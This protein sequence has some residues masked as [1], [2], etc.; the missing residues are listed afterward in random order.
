[1]STALSRSMAN[2]QKTTSRQNNRNKAKQ[3]Q[4]KHIPTHQNKHNDSQ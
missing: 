4:N 1:M 3:K 2:P